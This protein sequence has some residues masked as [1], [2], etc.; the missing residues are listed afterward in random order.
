MSILL[1][2]LKILCIHYIDKK[3]NKLI[4]TE[5]QDLKKKILNNN[6]KFDLYRGV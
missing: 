4:D 3:T 1:F 2:T 6:D 5:A